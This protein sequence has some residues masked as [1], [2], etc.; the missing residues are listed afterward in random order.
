M[1]AAW[2]ICAKWSLPSLGREW[3][4]DP[5][6]NKKKKKL[7]AAQIPP[8]WACRLHQ[9]LKENNTLRNVSLGSPRMGNMEKCVIYISNWPGRL[10]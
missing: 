1:K 2:V 10:A 4:L 7:L 9:G 5:Q 6:D 8:L 3:V